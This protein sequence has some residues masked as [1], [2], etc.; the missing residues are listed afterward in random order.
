M[1]GAMESANVIHT[2][3]SYHPGGVNASMADASVRFF[4]NSIDPGPVLTDLSTLSGVT[5]GLPEKY[6]GTSFWG[7]WGALGST[8]GGENKSIE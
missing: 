6:T 5:S 3:S 8:G 2:A 1:Y 4:S 7:V